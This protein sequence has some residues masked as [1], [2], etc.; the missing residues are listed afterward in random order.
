[1]EE[2]STEKWTIFYKASSDAHISC[3]DKLLK[4]PTFRYRSNRECF[5]YVRKKSEIVIKTLYTH[6]LHFESRHGV[7]VHFN[8]KFPM[9]LGHIVDKSNGI[10]M[11][12]AIFISPPP[13]PLPFRVH[14]FWISSVICIRERD[15]NFK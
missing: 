14:N 11:S 12:R 15:E 2:V 3:T 4:V 9:K 10:F 13:K 7:T 1:M 5:K 8:R 6:T